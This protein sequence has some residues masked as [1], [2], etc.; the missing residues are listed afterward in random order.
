MQ[1]S[2][3]NIQGRC[4]LKRLFGPSYNQEGYE[5]RAA[6]VATLPTPKPLHVPVVTFDLAYNGETDDSVRGG[7]TRAGPLGEPRLCR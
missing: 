7:S 6:R 2:F 5:I 3:T 4:A 1:Q